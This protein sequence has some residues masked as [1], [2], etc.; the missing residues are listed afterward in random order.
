MSPSQPPSTRRGF[1]KTTAGVSAIAIAGCLGSAPSKDPQSRAGTPQS[2]GNSPEAANSLDDTWPQ[3][4][5]NPRNTGYVSTVAG[6]GTDEPELA[7]RYTAGTPTMNTSPIVGDGTV[8]VP[9]SGNPGLIHAID[10]ETGDNVW[11]FE[12]AGYASSALALGDG[13]LFVGTWGK[14]F[15]ALDA[16][17]GDELWSQEIGHRFGSSSPV[18]VDDTIYVGTIGDGPLVVRGPEDEETFEAC[19]FLALDAETGERKWQYREFSEKENISSSPAVADGRVYFGGESGVYA[20]DSETGEEVWTRDIPTHP[21]SSPA[22]VDD[23]VYYG[24]PTTSDSG[25]PAEVWALD[26]STGETRWSVGIDDVSLRTSPAVA[27]GVV[28]VAASSVRTCLTVG[29]GESECS[30]VTRG[31]LYALD[32]A[33]GE[34]QWTAELETDTRSSPAVADGVIY[35]GCRD[36]LSA[37]TTAGENAW[38]VTFESDR[39]DGP[40]VK[41]SPA[42]ANGYVFIGASDG[43]LRAFS[44]AEST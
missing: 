27:D 11:Q 43:R 37:V 18:I 24:A 17:S 29:G 15:Y 3:F 19:A 39:G 16:E 1:L 14:Q 8:Y 25:P 42:V 13:M 44:A 5:A 30:G 4:G 41:S 33:S 31:Q 2:D 28:Y 26:G 36:G 7:W 22:V 9:G 40:Y 10:I 35:V 21:D 6:P 38:R 23:V 12:P 32:A 20:L 34:R